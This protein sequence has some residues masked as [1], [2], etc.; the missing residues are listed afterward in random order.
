MAISG[1]ALKEIIAYFNEHVVYNK[2]TTIECNKMIYDISA[3]NRKHEI[4]ISP[5]NIILM[6]D[7]FIYLLSKTKG[8][9]AH[10]LGDII[11]YEYKH[12]EKILDIA[13]KY[14]LPP[15]AVI[16]QILIETKHES[17][18]IE[19]M[20]ERGTLPRE[21]QKQMKEIIE[22]DPKFWFIRT[23]PNIHNKL[24]KLNCK[25]KLKYDLKHNGKC[26]DILFDNRCTYKRRSFNWIV[27]KPY[28]LFNSHLH[29]HDIQKTINNFS[30]F[31]TGLILYNDIICSVSFIKTIHVHIDTYCFLD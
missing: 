25:Y 24:G 10:R 18:K 7:T 8:T 3:I 22:N 17:H 12:K 23:V 28:V 27:F 16:S 20:M 5:S 1:K 26:P 13:K 14:N 4:I 15:M 11:L 31:G 2:L 30:R 19:K 9:M 21:I 6:R 29:I